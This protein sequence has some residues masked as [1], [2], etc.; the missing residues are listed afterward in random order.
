VSL[1]RNSAAIPIW[2]NNDAEPLCAVYELEQAQQAVA[3]EL[4]LGKLGPKN[5]VAQ[6]A[7][8]NYVP[9][10]KIREYDPLLESLVNINS[11]EDYSRLQTGIMDPMA[12]SRS[13]VRLWSPD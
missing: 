7:A 9:V 3:K 6:L 11:R 1:L 12:K 13:Q 10:S 2:E 4:R 8:V 5:L